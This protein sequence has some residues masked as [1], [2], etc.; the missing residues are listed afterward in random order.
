M[1]FQKLIQIIENERGN[2]V[3]GYHGSEKQELIIDPNKPTWFATNLD[4]E[5]MKYYGRYGNIYSAD[6]YLDKI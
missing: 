6:L 2:L 4:A 5:I 1:E 3:K